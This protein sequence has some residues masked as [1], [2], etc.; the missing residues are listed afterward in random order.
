MALTYPRPLRVLGLIRI[1]A[2]D[3]AAFG[4]LVEQRHKVGHQ[5]Q[6]PLAA[7]TPTEIK[8]V[9][10]RFWRLVIAVGLALLLTQPLCGLEICAAEGAQIFL[11]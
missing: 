3:V 7:L 8:L 1:E 11:R 9:Q 4:A 2:G 6:L 10:I 5:R